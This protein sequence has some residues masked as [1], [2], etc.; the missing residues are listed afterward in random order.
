MGGHPPPSGAGCKGTPPG[1]LPCP[2]VGLQERLPPEAVVGDWA[3]TGPSPASA[4]GASSTP[5]A[6]ARGAGQSPRFLCH[7]RYAR[8]A[9]TTAGTIVTDETTR[10]TAVPFMASEMPSPSARAFSEGAIVAFSANAPRSLRIVHVTP[11]NGAITITARLATR[12]RR[13]LFPGFTWRVRSPGC[14]RGS[15]HHRGGGVANR[16]PGKGCGSA[17]ARRHPRSP[18]TSMPRASRPRVSS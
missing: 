18:N 13:F 3:T 7:S 8:T 4:Q 2:A 15:D 11:S 10:P 5:R 9:N 6:A 1:R 14:R 16:R 17:A 12:P